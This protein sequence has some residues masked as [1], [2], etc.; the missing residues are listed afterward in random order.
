MLFVDTIKF[1]G[2]T[3]GE[4]KNWESYFLMIKRWYYRLRDSD[5]YYQDGYSISS[6]E[7]ENDYIWSF[8]ISCYHF[9]DWLERDNIATGD[10]VNKYI[11]D[12]KS[13]SICSDVCQSNKHAYLKRTKTDDLTTRIINPLIEVEYK[14]KKNFISMSFIANNGIV[15][16]DKL[17]E[18]CMQAW[19]EF[20]I[21][22]NLKIPEFK[23]EN[24]IKN[25]VKWQ[26]KV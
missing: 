13:L 21:S 26:M 25:F 11:K 7:M 10:E 17:I 2:K 16:I 5:F 9:K 1:T 22:K 20:I 15:N 19:G 23:E 4:D 3:K 12:S 8:F 6:L 14:N 18:D 24:S